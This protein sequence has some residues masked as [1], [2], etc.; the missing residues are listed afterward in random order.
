MASR[1]WT[2]SSTRFRACSGASRS[3]ACTVHAGDAGTGEMSDFLRLL[4]LFL[5]A[6]NPPAAACAF[7]GTAAAAAR[8]RRRMAAGQAVC[9]AAAL[10]LAGVLLAERILDGLEVAPESFRTG[11]GV[12][13]LA[14]GVPVIFLGRAS[15]AIATDEASASR[16]S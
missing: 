1:A 12:V 14:V 3:S 7:A 16:L 10:G 8:S 13:M 4:V 2:T 15:G 6:V 9:V 5:A 11:A